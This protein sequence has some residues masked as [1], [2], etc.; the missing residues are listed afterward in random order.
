MKK[1]CLRFFFLKAELT[2]ELSSWQKLFREKG[3]KSVQFFFIH[4]AFNDFSLRV[5]TFPQKFKISKYF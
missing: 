5:N 4:E 3:Y 2:T 1:G